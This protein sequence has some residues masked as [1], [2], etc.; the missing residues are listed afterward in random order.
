MSAKKIGL[1]TLLLLG[2]LII[3]GFFWVKNANN[4]KQEGSFEISINDAP[5]KIVRDDYGVAYVMAENKA[6][7]IRGQ[8]FVVAQDRLFQIEL[9]RALIKGEGASLTGKA[10]LESDIQMRVLDL[11]GNAKRSY[12][13]LDE[14]TKEM[15]GWYCEGFNAY[16]EVGK[17]EFPLELSLLGIEPQPLQP[18]DIVATAHFIGFFHSQNMSDEVLS[19]NLASRMEN[20]S[21]L[22]PLNINL[23]RSK[24]LDFEGDTLNGET[25]LLK[26]WHGALYLCLSSLTQ[27]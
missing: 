13:Y 26:K 5:I 19:L 25:A 7:V 17:D 15:L 27:S 6:D 8:A 1:F 9:Y 11:V 23:D 3:S 12:E 14:E 20:A 24:P 4:F 16:L 22:L 2:I 10:M 18:V 21:E